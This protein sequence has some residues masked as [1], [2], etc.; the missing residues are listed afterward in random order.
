MAKSAEYIYMYSADFAILTEF[1]CIFKNMT[2]FIRFN[3]E[4]KVF[5]CI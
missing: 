1:D 4:W 2:F 5:I 3:R